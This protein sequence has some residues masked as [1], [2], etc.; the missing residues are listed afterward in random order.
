MSKLYLFTTPGCH[1]CPAAKELIKT[2]NLDCEI[3][4]VGTTPGGENKALAAKVRG[5]PQFVI[6]DGAIFEKV[7]L[8]DEET[9]DRIKKEYGV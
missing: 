9:F 3:I 8:T 1:K 6:K 4:E 7:D 5:V 2:H